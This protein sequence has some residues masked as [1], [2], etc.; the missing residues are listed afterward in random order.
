MDLPGG[1]YLLSVGEH[2]TDGSG[3]GTGLI[4]HPGGETAS[5]P[6]VTRGGFFYARSITSAVLLLLLSGSVIGGLAC[7]S[8]SQFLHLRTVVTA[9]CM[10]R[11]ACILPYV[12]LCYVP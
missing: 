1:S 9:S 4:L 6:L 5:T 8:L 7:G 12:T 10:H 2:A 3:L 11:P